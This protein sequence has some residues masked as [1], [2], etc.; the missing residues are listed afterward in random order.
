M[1]LRFSQDGHELSFNGLY[2]GDIETPSLVA[3]I[4]TDFR[5]PADLS[6]R[7]RNVVDIWRSSTSPPMQIH[8]TFRATLLRD[9]SPVES[10]N[11]AL[12]EAYYAWFE[13]ER[14]PEGI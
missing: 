3:D 8:F 4:V 1:N 12:E 9:F 11:L 6:T 2:L 13:Y 5:G 7:L 10:N 14:T